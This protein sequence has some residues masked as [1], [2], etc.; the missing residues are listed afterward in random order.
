MKDTEKR[1]SALEA[2]QAQAQE[3]LEVEIVN[4]HDF[5]GRPLQVAEV[6]W[7]DNPLARIA[8]DLWEAL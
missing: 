1:I 2:Q 6:R 3:R 7:G 5:A 8:Q 4:G